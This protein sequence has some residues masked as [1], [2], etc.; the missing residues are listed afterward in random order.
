MKAPLLFIE[1]MLVIRC[2]RTVG[3]LFWL[4]KEVLLPS[5]YRFFDQEGCRMVGNGK[6][7]FLVINRSFFFCASATVRSAIKLLPDE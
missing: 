6:E 7:E 1:N 5:G 4:I 3:F 2:I